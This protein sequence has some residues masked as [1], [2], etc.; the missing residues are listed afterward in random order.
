LDPEA[1]KA[2]ARAKA[3]RIDDITKPNPHTKA[4]GA[5]T[6][7]EEDVRVRNKRRFERMVQ[8]VVSGD[9][10]LPKPIPSSSEL[11]AKLRSKSL[12]TEIADT[13]V[14]RTA[15]GVFDLW[16]ERASELQEHHSYREEFG[17]DDDWYQSQRKKPKLYSD[18]RSAESIKP[19]ARAAIELPVAGASYHPD[20]ES[21]QEL[22]RE[23]LEFHTRKADR[24]KKLQRMMPQFKKQPE[25]LVYEESDEDNGENGMDVEEE[26]GGSRDGVSGSKEEEEKVN[27][28]HVPRKSKEDREQE[29][30]LRRHQSALDA[31][32]RKKQEN[33]EWNA[34]KS[35]VRDIEDNEMVKEARRS[36]RQEVEEERDA[37]RIRR[38]GPAHYQHKEP[39]VLLTDELPGS[40]RALKPTSSVLQDRFDSL[41]RRNM[42]ETRHKHRAKRNQPNAQSN[43]KTYTRY[44]FRETPNM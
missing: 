38:I 2:R 9:R 35:M 32:A 24:R 4:E 26:E 29:L 37:I 1:R 16:D 27:L 31:I 8:E 7:T 21:H 25:P 28:A 30:R 6:K 36:A 13:T 44:A 33:R 42:V 39:E 11:A 14:K 43:K 40:L 17:F 23:A 41:Q 10:Q 34:F 15:N 20:Y 3:L 12:T 19:S 22:L 18:E 5:G